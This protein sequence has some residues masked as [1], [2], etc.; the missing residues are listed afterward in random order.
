MMFY[1]ERT[2]TEIDSRALLWGFL[3]CLCLEI[4]M[5]T[6]Y[7]CFSLYTQ[8]IKVA[9]AAQTLSHS[10]AV[11]LHTLRDLGYAEFQ[12]CEATAKFIDVIDLHH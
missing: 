10:V 8:S 2:T 7:S 4:L 6:L 1:V 9:L 3:S 12:H 5:H 11:A